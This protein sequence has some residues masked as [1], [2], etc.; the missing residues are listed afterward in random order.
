MNFTTTSCAPGN[1][2]R[3]YST[4]YQC[5]QIRQKKIGDEATRI[6]IA[7]KQLTFT[8]ITPNERGQSALKQYKRAY[9]KRCAF[10]VAL[11]TVE[12]GALSQRLHLNLIHDGYAPTQQQSCQVW[13]EK[14]IRKA[15]DLAHYIAK[16]ESQPTRDEYQGKT[17]GTLGQITR[18]LADPT[19]PLHINMAA[20]ETMLDLQTDNPHQPCEPLIKYEKNQLTRDQYRDIAARHLPKLHALLAARRNF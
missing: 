14:A 6:F 11:F 12:K 10:E 18:L 3:N 4:C 20:A 19:Q 9:L 16:P 7:D 13:Q 8:I 2:C 17:W 5:K 1:R 15:R